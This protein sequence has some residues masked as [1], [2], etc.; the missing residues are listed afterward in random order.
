M[1]LDS[2]GFTQV[3][4]IATD[5][6]QAAVV[7]AAN[8]P[9]LLRARGYSLDV[10]RVSDYLPLAAN[11]LLTNERTIAE[12]PELV[13]SLVKAI[14]RGITEAATHPDEA[15]DICLK[16]VPNLDQAD[17]KVQKE[18]LATS[19]EFWQIENPGYTDQE[20]WENMQNMLLEMG[21]MTNPLDLNKA[22]SNDFIK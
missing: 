17:E 2:I 10:I 15:Y 21:S 12:D 9:V 22:I 6:D 3:E 4:A 8:E 18:V 5:R 16:Y 7:Y 1:T 20:A 11:G 19:I 14:L 13:R